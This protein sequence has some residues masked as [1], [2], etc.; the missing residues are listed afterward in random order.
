MIERKAAVVI[1]QTDF[2]KVCGRRTQ[3][4]VRQPLTFKSLMLISW[5]PRERCVLLNIGMTYHIQGFRQGLDDTCSLPALRRHTRL[6]QAG[7]PTL[8]RLSQPIA[9][10][11]CF[12]Q[13]VKTT[14]SCMRSVLAPTSVD[15]QSCKTRRHCH[16]PSELNV[17]SSGKLLQ[18]PTP[19]RYK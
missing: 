2:A 6:S 16:L 9:R 10:R 7:T 19:L 3:A 1:C 4:P 8:S 13:T 14:R 17:F 12:P 15:L 18:R 11:T 5:P